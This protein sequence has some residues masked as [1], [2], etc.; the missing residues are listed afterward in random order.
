M[1]DG[2][3][4]MMTVEDKQIR[5]EAPRTQRVLLLL[6]SV[7]LP[8]F[9]VLISLASLKVTPFGDNTLIIADANGL[10]INYASYAGRM[11]Q[12]QEGIVY[13]FEKGLGGN[14]MPHIGGT[15]LNP[16]YF[17]FCF[18]DISDYLTVYTFVSVLNFSVCG[19]TMY[20]LLAELYGHKRSN[21]IFST[22]YALIGFHVANVFQAVFFTATQALPLMVLGLR[23]IFQG[24]N[25]LLYILSIVYTTLTSAYFGFT[26]CV[27]SL[28]MFLVF[29]WANRENLEGRKRS[30]IINYCIS[31]LCAGL[32]PILV[33]LPGILG[34]RGGRLDQT[35][36]ADFSFWENM[37]FIE[38]GSKLFT[39]ANNIS[40]LIN[41]L[42][43]IFVGILPIVLVILFFMNREIEK[44]K[45]EAA[46]IL[47]LFYLVS[48]YIVAFNML[49]HGGT[50]PNW[51]NYRYSFIF[52]FILLM[53]A[54]YEWQYIDSIPPEHLKKTAVIMLLSTMIIFSKKYGFVMGGEV[55]MDFAI[56]LVMY[57]AYQMHRKDPVKNP[58]QVF[59]IIIILL[60]S[61]HMMLNYEFSTRNLLKE[62]GWMRPLSEYQ[63]VVSKVDPLVQAI[64]VADDGFYR[65]EI[66]EQRSGNCGNDPMLYGYNGVGHGGSNE[67]NFV[68]KGLNKLGINWFDMRSYYA[69]GIPAATDTLFGLKYIVAKEDLSE[70]KG[71]VKVTDTE[72]WNLYHNLNALPI[73]FLSDDQVGDTGT[74]FTDVFENLNQTWAA[75]SGQEK[76]VF[77]LEEEITFS[78]H[79]YSEQIELTG[80]EAREI[81]E[82]RDAELEASVSAA[83]TSDSSANSDSQEEA[84][85]GALKE[86]PEYCSYIQYTWT[87]KQDGP[88]YS[89]NR[90]GLMDTVGSSTPVLNYEGYYHKGDTVIG[91]LPV[92]ADSV[93]RYVMEDVSG[94]FRA[95][96]AD[97]GALAE[98]SKNV[99]ERPTSIQKFKEN[100]LIGEFTADENQKLVFTIPYDSGW[101]L[102]V[103][104]EE[105]ELEEIL[106]VLM[107][108]EVE[109]GTH[110]YEMKYTPDGLRIGVIISVITLIV[111]IIYICFGRKW[112]NR[113]PEKRKAV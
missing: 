44:R 81:V 13:S 28:C 89:Y 84:K 85:S 21:L 22:T 17:L 75:I 96:Y 61:L 66:N 79:N 106:D 34:I 108:A 69:E 88:V 104:G 100:Y 39:G 97:E 78:S 82:K 47:L 107:A 32:L 91:Y 19:L 42:P 11:M 15:L 105:I 36:L 67:R 83:S 37:P 95:A 112:I 72:D 86:A 12:G 60:T 57:L 92:Y 93:S 45:K 8:F 99:A 80:E 52:S 87:A 55:L 30:V 50:S 7:V 43:N 18:A 49:M 101:T 31:S 20:I 25:P 26:Y 35:S 98:L 59:E 64:K 48:F 58:T 90:S 54:A 63:E 113:I 10:Y 38:I 1:K 9:I 71:Y 73:V 41:G 56:L 77:Q 33:W 94:R 4:N 68:R 111:L 23:K 51:F 16:F 14:M 2:L 24:K 6:S 109:S 40:E 3:F 70:E 65:M 46:G 27:A 103:D 62:E 74:D 29:F 5:E 110:Q 53:V 76:Q 102:T